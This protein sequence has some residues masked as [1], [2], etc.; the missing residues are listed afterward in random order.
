MQNNKLNPADLTV[1]SFET[2]P[3]ATSAN[4]YQY[5]RPFTDPTAETYCFVCPAYTEACY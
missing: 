3:T 4:L 5:P 2:E 1:T